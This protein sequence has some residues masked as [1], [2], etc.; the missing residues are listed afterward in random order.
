MVID[1]SPDFIDDMIQFIK[2]W[3]WWIISLIII[4]EISIYFWA[5][6]R[7]N[8]PSI[9]PN[10]I[11][12]NQYTTNKYDAAEEKYIESASFNFRKEIPLFNLGLN[13]YQKKDYEESNRVLDGINSNNRFFWEVYNAL[14]FV[15]FDWGHSVLDKEE[16]SYDQT[17]VLWEL[18]E[19]KFNYGSYI[20]FF[21]LFPYREAIAMRKSRLEVKDAIAKLPEWRDNCLN[22]PENPDQ[23]PD[24][25]S[26]GGDGKEGS[27]S[28][29]GK[30]ENENENSKGNN[31]SKGDENTNDNPSTN[32]DREGN[33]GSDSTDSTDKNSEKKKDQE[34]ESLSDKREKNRQNREEKKE[35]LE[36]SKSEKEELQKAKERIQNSNSNKDYTRH[37]EEINIITSVKEI[38]EAMKN[39]KW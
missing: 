35:N 22:P 3:K 24:S 7:L 4:I 36:I 27:E 18:S 21:H 8:H 25:G 6:N 12:I 5:Q 11:G 19:K 14:G 39:A 2:K 17:L 31:D 23:E 16:C 9:N 20:A 28:T 32:K 15:L 1:Q 33:E 29:E 26:G 37:K 30:G 10:R 38:E 34:K 13:Y